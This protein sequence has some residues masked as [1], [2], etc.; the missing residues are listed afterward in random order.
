M[1]APVK[2]KPSTDDTRNT[3]AASAKGVKPGRR[4]PPI[5]CVLRE[6]LVHFVAIGI[7]VVGAYKVLDPEPPSAEDPTGRRIEITEDDLRQLAVSWLAQG[8]PAPTPEQMRALVDQKVTSEILVREAMALGLDK[9]DEIIKRRLAQKMD[10]LVADVAA[11]AP[12]GAGELEAWFAQNS[13]RFAL[14]PRISFRHLYFSPDVRGAGAHD[15]AA[16]SLGRISGRPPDAPE[17]AGIGDPFMFRDY[18]GSSTPE[19][20]AREFGPAFSD[21]LFQLE[22]GS[23][24]GPIESGYGWHLIWIDSL[25]PGRVPNYEE[26]KPQVLAGPVPRGQGARRC[27]DTVPLRDCRSAA[28]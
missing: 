7:I 4:R 27:R 13:E 17:V 24:Q 16:T 26:V 2:D 1:D 20:M 10:F 19:Q 12:P 15:A 25:E 11:M 23:W 21:A 6:P 3:G 14:P 22:P 28:G 8:R 9:D 18:Y 5:G